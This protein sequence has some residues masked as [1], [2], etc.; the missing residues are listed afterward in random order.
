MPHDGTRGYFAGTLPQ[1]AVERLTA[2]AAQWREDSAALRR[3][4]AVGHAELLDACAVELQEA[5]A[6]NSIRSASTAA[7]RG[8]AEA[9]APDVL[10][11]VEQVAV[12]LGTTPTWVYAHWQQLG[13]G[14]KLGRRTLRFSAAKLQRYLDRPRPH[15]R[16]R[17]DPL[18]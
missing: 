14:Q 7:E 3:R 15:S 9:A 18:C 6:G 11:T 13:C 1:P 10:L 5:L 12:R 16:G 4:G 17:D 8:K 2:L